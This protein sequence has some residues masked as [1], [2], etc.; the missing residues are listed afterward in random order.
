MYDTVKVQED[1]EALKKAAQE[2]EELVTHRRE[3]RAVD[4]IVLRE[5]MT[6]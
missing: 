6:L 4:P 3:A 5:P 1:A 2:A